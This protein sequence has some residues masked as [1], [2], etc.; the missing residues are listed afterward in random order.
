MVIGAGVSLNKFINVLDRKASVSS[1]YKVLADHVQK[2]KLGTF[3][4]QLRSIMLLC[5][6][7]IKISDSMLNEKRENSLRAR[8]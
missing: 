5:T 3:L 2:V 8:A 4:L 7:G 6:Q 1:G